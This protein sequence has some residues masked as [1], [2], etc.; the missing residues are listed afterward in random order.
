MMKVLLPGER[1][2]SVRGPAYSN[3][4][5][6]I[7]NWYIYMCVYTADLATMCQ[8]GKKMCVHVYSVQYDIGLNNDLILFYLTS[9]R[10]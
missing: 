8:Q 6:Y 2:R 7:L 3:L 4:Y 1:L 9:N 5:I 10:I